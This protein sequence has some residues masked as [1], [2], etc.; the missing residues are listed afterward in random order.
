VNAR[1]YLGDSHTEK[2]KKCLRVLYYDLSGGKLTSLHL[3]QTTHK[4]HSFLS[5]KEIVGQPRLVIIKVR[6]G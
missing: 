3:I 6:L 1:F 5:R 4:N 2:N